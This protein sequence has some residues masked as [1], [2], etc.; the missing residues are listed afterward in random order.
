MEQASKYN[1]FVPISEDKSIIFNS[2]SGFYGIL[3]NHVADSL[4]QGSIE[5]FVEDKVLYKKLKKEGVITDSSVDETLIVDNV[6]FFARFDTSYFHLTVNP[7]LDCNLRCWYCYESHIAHSALTQDK[8]DAIFK[9]L[10]NRYSAIPFKRLSFNLFGG[11]PFY[12]SAMAEQLIAGV[13]E[14]CEPLAIACDYNITT[15]GTLI[16]DQLLRILKD[17]K[18]L[19]QI[20]LDGNREKHNSVR[21]YK[22]TDLGTFDRILANLRRIAEELSQ[23][24]LRIRINYDASTLD[25][26]ERLLDD[27]DFLPRENTIIGLHKVWQVQ[28]SDVDKQKFFDFIKKANERLFVVDYWALHGLISHTCYADLYSQAVINYDGSIFKCTARDF[29]QTEKAGNLGDDGN[30][31]WNTQALLDRLATR[32]PQKCRDC[33]LYPSCP[34]FCS[35]DLLE[36]GDMSDRC[37]FSIMDINDLV[38]YNFNQ[39]ITHS[40]IQKNRHNEKRIS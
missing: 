35:Q 27:L 10:K 31:T 29:S 24:Q 7:T 6:R 23:Y 4:R 26:G 34:A 13:S 37:R 15:N 19:F 12:R 16:S 28:E 33:V 1:I 3:S 11:E 25:E 38:I 30:I 8:A 18:V 17:K 32:Q 9:L 36:K 40:I 39:N 14:F 22:G 2:L 20:T 21:A 5:D